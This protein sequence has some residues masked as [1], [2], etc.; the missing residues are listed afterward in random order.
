MPKA[1]SQRGKSTRHR[2]VEAARTKLTQDGYDKLTL[3]SLATDL[4][5]ALGNLQYYFSTREALIVEIIDSEAA[6]VITE[7]RELV[8]SPGEP[9]H[10]LDELVELL[11]SRWRSE[12]GAI[13]AT[14]TFLALHNATFQDVYR[15]TY[16]SFYVEIERSVACAVPGLSDAECATR[17]RV[18][19]A[20]IDGASLQVLDG[21]KGEFY[22]AT[23]ATAIEVALRPG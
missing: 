8:D 3:R 12:S 16:D 14:M 10:I 6:N 22:A 23:K 9:E 11:L 1:S 4:D 20:L 13:F 7:L 21:S 19:T 17:A 18:L 2:I 15:E 5:I